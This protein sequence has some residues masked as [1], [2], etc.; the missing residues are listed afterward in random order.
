MART[1]LSE[2]VRDL[3]KSL[4]ALIARVDQFQLNINRV[5]TAH[6][7]TADLLTETRSQL[8]VIEERLNELKKA[9]EESGRRNWLIVVAFVGCVLTLLG[10]ILLTVLRR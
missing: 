4:A 7:K 2:I 10:N 1:T 8:A 6:E 9:Y 3:E 5:E